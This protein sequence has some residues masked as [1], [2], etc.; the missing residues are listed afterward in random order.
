MT[1]EQL[2]RDNLKGAELKV[3]N[4]EIMRLLATDLYN[5]TQIA[6]VYNRHARTIGTIRAQNKGPTDPWMTIGESAEFLYVSPSVIQALIDADYIETLAFELDSSPGVTLDGTPIY[7]ALRKSA[8]FKHVDRWV[9][10]FDAAAIAGI[11]KSVIE[12]RARQ[13]K[14]VCLKAPKGKPFTVNSRT[15]LRRLYDLSQISPAISEP[16]EEQL[17]I[18]LK[19]E[20]KRAWRKRREQIT[21]RGSEIRPHYTSDVIREETVIR[22]YRELD[23]T[24]FHT[25]GIC[26]KKTTIHIEWDDDE[27]QPT[28]NI[29]TRV[30]VTVKMSAR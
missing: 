15:S 11:S 20:K 24:M 1:R 21:N 13:N 6:E 19:P 5:C 12:T 7:L 18:P 25:K 28:I 3:R 22:C 17:E 23:I 26:S 27:D 16:D 2:S 14:V 30:P 10:G 8:L 4:R 9:S 29:H